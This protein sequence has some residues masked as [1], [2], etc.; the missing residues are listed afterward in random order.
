MG[1]GLRPQPIL[2]INAQRA[3]IGKRGLVMAITVRA[4]LKS[5]AGLVAALFAHGNASAALAPQGEM[6]TISAFIARLRQDMALRRRFA[7]SPAA[8]LRAHGIDP[9]PY[10]FPDQMSDAQLDRLLAQ[11]AQKQDS[12]PP[13]QAPQPQ[14]TP[15]QRP[16][17]PVAVYGPPARPPQQQRPNQPPAPV[18]GP[19]GTPR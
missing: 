6:L 2:R 4:L 9:A 7:D 5:A 15:P 12:S 19:P 1:F 17:G 10:R 3:D 8:V 16:S 11:F 14:P 18:Y 13:L